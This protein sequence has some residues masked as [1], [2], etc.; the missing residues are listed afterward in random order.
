MA[1]LSLQPTIRQHNGKI[2]VFYS[3]QQVEAIVPVEQ[4]L[5]KSKCSLLTPH[6]TGYMHK[7]QLAED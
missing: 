7:H 1:K 2:I 6:F 3:P 4:R 5:T